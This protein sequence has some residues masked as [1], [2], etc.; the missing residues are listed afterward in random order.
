MNEHWQ[1]CDSILETYIT[2]SEKASPRIW[3]TLHDIFGEVQEKT[4]LD[5]IL[6]IW[7]YML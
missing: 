2:Q 1:H 7:I 4:K 6:F 3:H 5:N